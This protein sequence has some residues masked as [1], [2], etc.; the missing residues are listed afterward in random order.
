MKKSLKD[1]SLASLGL[2]SVP[3]RFLFSYLVKENHCSRVT[4]GNCWGPFRCNCNESVGLVSLTHVFSYRLQKKTFHP[5]LRV[6][7][8]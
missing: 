2:V 4:E 5:V 3:L 8:D 6:L 7:H 1:A